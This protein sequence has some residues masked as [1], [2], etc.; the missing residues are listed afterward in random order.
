MLDSYAYFAICFIIFFAIVYRPGKKAILN[1]LD[2]SIQEVKIDLDTVVNRKIQAE[3]ELAELKEQM[4]FVEAKHAE[5][6]E[7]AKSEIQK[8]YENRCKDFDKT[9][10]YSEIN[11]KA[12]MDQM[13]RDAMRELENAILVKSLNLVSDYFNNNQSSKI[14]LAIVSSFVKS[15]QR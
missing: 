8:T 10:E 5:M 3:K 12:R 11:S 9:L 6:L 4:S 2:N 15:R 1:L 13:R 14:D 7:N